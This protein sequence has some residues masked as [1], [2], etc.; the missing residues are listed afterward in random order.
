MSALHLVEPAP[1]A[2]LPDDLAAL[3]RAHGLARVGVRP[4]LPAYVRDLWQRRH[5]ALA[6]GAARAYSRTSSTWLGQL[7]ALLTPLLWA[8][9]YFLVFGLLLDTSRGVPNYVGFLVVGVFLFHF[10]SASI[11]AGAGAVV[12]N[13]GL[14]ASLRFPR[15]LLPVAAVWSE[16][17]L[18]LP[19]LAVLV[20]LVPLSGEPLQA[21]WLLLPLAVA[22]QWLFGTGVAFIAARLVAQVRD[23]R[24]LVP[25]V[26]RVLMYVSGVF[27]SLDHYVGSGVA[28]EVL[29]RQPVA[30]F[31]EL[32]RAVLLSDITAPWSLW[33][34]AA[35]WAVGT[36]LV[37][38][39][40]FWRAE[41]RYGRG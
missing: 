12:G 8:G 39:V 22:L 3:A 32:G 24:Q 14:I 10:S 28:G 38:F 15:A 18:L 9:V 41:A 25:F 30:V 29:R 7:W 17:L 33:A 27:F 13:Q 2:P 11:N 20:V 19:A 37:G 16:L 21:S 36:F 1:E 34:W 4:P 26:L 6:L 40:F 31:L 35:G 5:F 23:L